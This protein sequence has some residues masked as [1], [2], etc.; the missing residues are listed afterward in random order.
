MTR[1]F[2][3]GSV[4]FVTKPTTGVSTGGYIAIIGQPRVDLLRAFRANKPL[5]HEGGEVE[6]RGWSVHTG[7]PGWPAIGPD[8][9]DWGDWK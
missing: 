4:V 3:I 9:V 1:K 2:D 7:A 6:A 8:D 5:L